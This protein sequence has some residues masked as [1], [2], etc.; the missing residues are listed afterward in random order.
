MSALL[1]LSSN[2]LICI[3]TALVIVVPIA[4]FAGELP[5]TTKATIQQELENNGID[6]AL[7][8]LNVRVVVP[9]SKNPYADADLSLWGT[10]I[11]PKCSLTEKVPTIVVAC[12]YRREIMGMLYLPLVSHGYA[13]F[14]VDI[15]GTG[16]SEG[17]WV[18]FDLLE[19][20]DIKYV[21]D[22]FVPTYNWS[23]G[24]IGMIGVS[25]LGIIQM[26]TAGLCDR[27]PITGEPVHLKA[28]YPIVPKSDAYLDIVMHGGSVDLEFI[29]MWLGLVDILGVLPQLL[30]FGENGTPNLDDIQQASTNWMNHVKGIATQMDWIT[31]A[32]HMADGTFYD[33]RSA[34]IYW[35]VKPEG[36]WGIY[37]GDNFTI[38][39]KL[40]VCITAGWFDIFT[41]GS[42]NHYTYGLS[43]HKPGDKALII[44]EWYHLDSTFAPGVNSLG[45]CSFAA[46]WFDRHIKGKEDCF[47]KDFPVLMYVMGPD[48]WRAEKSWPL[49]ASRLENKTMYLSKKCAPVIEGDW[50]TGKETNQIYS[51]VDS[52]SD[53]DLAGTNPVLYHSGELLLMH[54]SNSRSSVRWFMGVQALAGQ[55]SKH[56][57]LNDL[58]EYK[59]YEDER[60]DDWRIPTFTSETLE[61]DT[62]IV[63]PIKLT[64][65]AKTE[66][67]QELAQERVDAATAAIKSMFGIDTNLIIDAMTERDVQWVAELDDVF[68]EGRARNITSGW[69]RASHRQYDPDEPAGT[70][71]HAIDPDYT[72]FEPFND[73]YD[74]YPK[75]INENELYQYAIELWPTCNV[76]KKG[77]RIRVTL[78]G[79]DFPHQ[80]PILRPSTNTIVIDEDHKASIEFTSTNSSGEGT[81]WKWVDGVSSY[82]MKD[83]DEPD[84]EDGSGVK[85]SASINDEGTGSSLGGCGSYAEASTRGGG[86]APVLPG[87]AGMLVLM[88]LPFAMIMA[89]RTARRKI[90]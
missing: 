48:R 37:E 26:M 50:F 76:F 52:L 79:S 64:F 51:L 53:E 59:Y 81:T 84:R 42:L 60:D 56:V 12:P 31:D 78:S 21:V 1:R 9:K 4:A 19:Q 36:G 44:G 49:P 17:E 65:W 2:R 15:R 73:L 23:N 5:A 89:H 38:P 61:K 25:Y 33:R 68:P 46:R 62:E 82:L 20:Y 32:A 57:L 24:D 45:N 40:P 41:R 66:Y 14:V 27:D 43:D 90:R 58:N 77:H 83:T 29:P 8:D 7:I 72:A 10:V 47:M 74:K 87:V 70:M 28:I 39:S 85:T 11:R 67:S 86:T 18:S 22:D 34:M 16:S 71:E 55:I 63:G 54:G 13:L 80:L 6:D 69:L 75:A 35:P 88:A 30:M 3:L